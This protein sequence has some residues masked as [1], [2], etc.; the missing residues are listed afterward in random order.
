[1]LK[2]ISKG[3]IEKKY[4]TLRLGKPFS[5]FK[6]S[7]PGSNLFKSSS[8]LY[9]LSGII[10]FHHLMDNIRPN[11]KNSQVMPRQHSQLGLGNY[12]TQYFLG[13]VPD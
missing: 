4:C 6:E 7:K 12:D 5:S 10:K 9:C 11:A 1:M 2:W 3:K 13:I 8:Q